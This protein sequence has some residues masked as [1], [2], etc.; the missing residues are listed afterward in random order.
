MF[1]I[2]RCCIALAANSDV[3]G[4]LKAYSSFLGRRHSR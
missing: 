2:D 4:D 1:R 3:V